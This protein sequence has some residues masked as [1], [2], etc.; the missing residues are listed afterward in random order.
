MPRTEKL[1]RVAELK[2]RIEGSTALLLAEY[3]G[4]TVSDIT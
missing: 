4:L 1:E 2:R 3:R